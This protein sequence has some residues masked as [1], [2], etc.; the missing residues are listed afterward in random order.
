MHQPQAQRDQSDRRPG[1]DP[2]R[3]PDHRDA[4]RERRRCREERIIQRHGRPGPRQPVPRARPPYRRGGAANRG[5]DGAPSHRPRA[6]NVV[7]DANLDVT[8]ARSWAS[9]DSWGRPHRA[10]HERLRSQLRRRRSPA[11]IY[12][13]G[14]P[15][16]D[17]TVSKAIANGIAYVTEDRKRYGLNLIEDIRRN[18]SITALSTAVA[19][20]L[21]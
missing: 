9:P 10:R 13:R 8:R 14:K 2:P 12:K 11:A 4:R 19:V 6:R 18:I 16:D 15:I 7:D 21:A 1:H 17:P 20:R 3:R 5:L